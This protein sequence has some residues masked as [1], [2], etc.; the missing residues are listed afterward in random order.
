MKCSGV[1]FSVSRFPKTTH[2][3]WSV[4]LI[5]G[6]M[7]IQLR[8]YAY[9]LGILLTGCSGHQQSTVQNPENRASQFIGDSFQVK[10]VESGDLP[11]L[12]DKAKITIQKSA[13]DK[14]FMFQGNLVVQELAP[15]FSGLKSHVVF[16]HQVDKKVYL[17]EASKGLVI[18]KNYPQTLPLAEFP[19]LEESPTSVT[20]DFNA[21]MSRLFILGDWQVRDFP[22]N[23]SYRSVRAAFSYIERAAIVPGNAL[24]I[25]QMALLSMERNGVATNNPVEVIYY[26]SP[27]RPNE[28]FKPTIAPRNLDRM[29]FFEVLS[30]FNDE[31]GMTSFAAKM[32]IEKPIVYSISANTPKEYRDAIRD[33]ILYWNKAFGK[34]VIQVVDA[35]AGVMGPTFNQ[36]IVQWVEWDSAGFAYADAQMDPRTG[37][38]LHQQIYFTSAWAK[39]GQYEVKN[40]LRNNTV[41]YGLSGFETT[42]LC[43]RSMNEKVAAEMNGLFS[44]ETDKAKILKAT[45]DLLREVVAHEVG[46]TLGLRHNFAGSLA[47]TYNVEKRQELFKTYLETGSTPSDVITSSSVMDYQY[48][49]ESM[50]NGDQIAKSPKAD[51]YD[52]KAIQALYFG[53]TYQNSELPLFCTDSHHFYLDCQTY[54]V[55]NSY[56]A[57]VKYSGRHYLDLLPQSMIK[58]YI[59]AKAPMYGDLPKPVSEVN[60][61]PKVAAVLALSN[62]PDFLKLLKKSGRLLSIERRFPVVNPSNESLVRRAVVDLISADL[63][64]NGKFDEVLVGTSD[65]LTNGLFEKFNK[66]LNDPKTIRGENPDGKPYEFSAEELTTMKE[67]GRLFFARL[68]EELAKTEV[69]ILSGKDPYYDLIAE[70][71]GIKIPQPEDSNPNFDTTELSATFAPYLASRAEYFLLTASGEPT[72]F[73][74]N[75][76]A[77][78]TLPGGNSHDLNGDAKPTVTTMSLPNFKFPLSLRKSAAGLLKPDRAEN[79]GWGYV[80]LI[81]VQKTFEKMVDDAL[82]G[83]TAKE[84]GP[85]NDYPQV[86]INWILDARAVRGV[87]GTA[88]K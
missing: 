81:G 83:V 67:A 7:K 32:D 82:P 60:M 3:F 22:E 8:L 61:N 73:K 58:S 45:Q 86:V 65:A 29:G 16:F 76:S 19:V 10:K 40:F 27:Y 33:G 64:R 66:L 72:V 1:E 55:G 43:N 41:R 85:L 26:L 18:A 75:M 31:S 68:N 77:S 42:P 6:E 14:E 49:I 54:D 44:S 48:P 20:F 4:S 39:A 35:P 37:E 84:S 53:K 88:P 47:A 71:Y 11:V 2:N 25:H 13:L 15:M 51:D 9:A 79:P 50:M 21:G 80:E 30:Q 74:R 63:S 24:E 17:I 38:V 70:M 87:L 46:H 56:T 62:E 28:N 12:V 78:W 36:N 5:G 34:T 59:L 52:E 57:W 23:P 69:S